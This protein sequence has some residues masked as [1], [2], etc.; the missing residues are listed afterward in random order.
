MNLAQRIID[1]IDCEGFV[2]DS[3]DACWIF[4]T[5]DKHDAE[6]Q[7]EVERL[8]A[9]LLAATEK[10]A[11]ILKFLRRENESSEAEWVRSTYPPTPNDCLSLL[12]CYILD[13]FPEDCSD[14]CIAAW[15]QAAKGPI[16][17]IYAEIERLR[18]ELAA[19]VDLTKITPS[20]TELLAMAERSPAPQEWNDEATDK[21]LIMREAYLAAMAAADTKYADAINDAAVHRK[22]ATIVAACRRAWVMR[23]TAYQ[24]ALKIFNKKKKN[25]S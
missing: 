25:A 18:A 20:N 23:K 13:H 14:E 6:Q 22:S 12:S 24:S 3:V 4:D 7:A 19:R 1:Y 9:E 16:V 21:E 11:T 10:L 2:C 17:K 8:R 5:V 15:E